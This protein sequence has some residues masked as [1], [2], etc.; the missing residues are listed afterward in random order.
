MSLSKPTRP[1]R[2]TKKNEVLAPDSAPA[3][4]VA[5]EAGTTPNVVANEFPTPMV[6]DSSKYVCEI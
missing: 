2:S 5:A 1:I 4:A 3:D 6:S